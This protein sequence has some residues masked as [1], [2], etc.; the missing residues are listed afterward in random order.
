MKKIYSA[1]LTLAVM[2]GMIVTFQSPAQ[3]VTTCSVWRPLVGVRQN[4][5]GMTVNG[6]VPRGSVYHFIAYY[7]WSGPLSSAHYYGTSNIL[8]RTRRTNVDAVNGYVQFPG[9]YQLWCRRWH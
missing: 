8:W 2:A 9:G 5:Y 4:R 7:G 6:S 3:A 1:I